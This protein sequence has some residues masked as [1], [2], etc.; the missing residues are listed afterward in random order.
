M[1][2]ISGRS[3]RRRARRIRP[4]VGLHSSR[5]TLESNY[6]DRRRNPSLGRES[7]WRGV[8]GERVAQPRYAY[9]TRP[10]PRASPPHPCSCHTSPPTAPHPHAP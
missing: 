2:G 1:L 3:R 4:P 7:S 9:A 6:N 10:V 5:L 8:P